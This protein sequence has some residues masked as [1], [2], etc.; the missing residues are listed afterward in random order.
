MECAV[1]TTHGFYSDSHG[2]TNSDFTFYSVVCLN[3]IKN[4]FFIWHAFCLLKLT[5]LMWIKILAKTSTLEQLL[6]QKEYWILGSFVISMSVVLV[7]AL[8]AFSR[9]FVFFNP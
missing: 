9:L 5:A 1:L 3:Y 4:W 8:N 2:V 6:T 7:R